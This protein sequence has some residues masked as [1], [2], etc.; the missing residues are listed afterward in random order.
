MKTTTQLCAF[1]IALLML[2]STGMAQPA[3]EILKDGAQRKKIMTA[4]CN[5]H[6]MMTEMMGHMTQNDH[7]MQMMRG[8]REMMQQMMGDQEMA[9]GMEK[10]DVKMAGMMMDNMMSAMETDSTLCKAMCGK[11]MQ[12]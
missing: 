8:N 1:V 9:K 4:I 5:D 10:K 11:M 12:N 7:A 2:G 3:D 6:E